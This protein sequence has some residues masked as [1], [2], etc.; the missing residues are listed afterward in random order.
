MRTFAIRRTAPPAH[1][2]TPFWE[3]PEHVEWFAR[4]TPDRRLTELLADRPPGVRVLDVGCAAGRNTVWCARAGFDVH[5]LDAS[6]A[7]VARTRQ[8]VAG[9]LGERAARRRV[10]RGVMTD[11][12]AFPDAS[13]DLVACIGV[14]PSAPTAAAWHAAVSEIARVLRPGATF[15]LTHFSPDPDPGAPAWT[16]VPGAPGRYRSA[17]HGRNAYL[18]CAAELDR[19]LARHG[20]APTVA[21]ARVPLTSM[22]PNARDRTVLN[23]LHRRLPTEEALR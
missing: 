7:M 15:L 14:L 11:L 17:E 13:F 4:R 21:T 1:E 22:N 9:V 16:P 6:R 3:R 18:L 19:D 5:A 2:G 12:G 8:R 20:F 10:R 23:A